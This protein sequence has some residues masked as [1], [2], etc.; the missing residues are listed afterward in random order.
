MPQ[1]FAVFSAHMKRGKKTPRFLWA[2]FLEKFQE[3]MFIA[4]T[5]NCS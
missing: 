2:F 1:K 5:D 3:F 4:Y